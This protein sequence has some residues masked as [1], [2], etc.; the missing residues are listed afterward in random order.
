MQPQ[1]P[2]RLRLLATLPG[3]AAVVAAWAVLQLWGLG[4]TPFHTKG[5][6]REAIVV[7]E[8]VQSGNW[9]LARRNA[10]ELPAKPPL[11]HW[12]GAVASH[13]AGAVSELTVRLPSA[14]QSLGCALLVFLAGG[15]LYGT[16]SGLIGALALLTS[17]E[18]LRAATSA[19][20]D[21]TL[22]SGLTVSF[23]ALSLQ[24]RAARPA[25]V[26]LLYAGVAWATLSKGPVGIALPSLL[27]LALCLID[28]SPRFALDLRPVRGLAC[29][30]LIVG[31]WYALAAMQGGAEFVHKQILDENVY[32]FLGAKSATG[33]HRHSAAYLAL[34]LGLGLLPWTPFLPSLAAGLWRER[35]TLDGR[36][37]RL[38][39]LLWIAVVFAFYALPASKRG[40]YALPLYPAVCLLLGWWL[41]SL[42]RGEAHSRILAGVLLALASAIAVAATAAGLL[43]AA[44]ACGVPIG[45]ALLDLASARARDD[46]SL[47]SAVL[48]AHALPLALLFAATGAGAL[49]AAW[50]AHARRWAVAVLGLFATMTALTVATRLAVLPAVA[51]EQTRRRFA[52]AVKARVG[53]AAAVF[54]YRHFDYG[55]VY[56]WGTPMAVYEEP[57]AADGP[58]FL[59]LS[60]SDW[61]RLPPAARHL[62]ERVTGIESGR[63][64]NLGHLVLARRVA[65]GAASASEQVR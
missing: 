13:L 25:G 6:P 16:T 64:G 50:G 29:V 37:P 44:A 32:R 18:W 20:V 45:R 19:R 39:A 36:D 2:S 40:V 62:Y 38:V 63:S 46:L 41:P 57:L 53:D 52:E 1:S 56:Y 22:A 35:G 54:A 12:L 15:V 5:E 31:G 55:L 61:S 10:V 43:A 14:I 8:I 65:D 42:W 33:G 24:R 23:F 27:V 34:M 59:V 28:R 11:F 21:M 48:D 9:V 26:V 51:G 30:T 17:F 4:A 7:A 49:A 58:P 60:E 47:A 3:A